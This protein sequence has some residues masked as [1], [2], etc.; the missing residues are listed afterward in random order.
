MHKSAMK[1][2]IFSS[3]N[4]VISGILISVLVIYL[5]NKE[6]VMS[7]QRNKAA[8]VRLLDEVWT[9]GNLQVADQLIASQ[10]KIRHDP[11]DPW[12][13]KTLD[14]ATYK[15]RVSMSRNIFPDLKFHIED[16]MGDGDKVAVSWRLTGTQKGSI[17]GLPITNKK[18][19]VSG[20]TIYYFSDGKIIGHWQVLDRLGFLHQLGL[21]MEGR[22]IF[23]RPPETK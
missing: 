8:V 11:G 23:R 22:A 1:K 3:F 12:E 20:I 5:F 18:V 19:D 14:L 6:Q 17:P 9:K 21:K 15:E 16:L 2:S 10:Y 4:L 13:G 7:T